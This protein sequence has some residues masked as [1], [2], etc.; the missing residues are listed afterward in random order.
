MILKNSK[1]GIKYETHLKTDQ[2]KTAFIIL[3][4]SLAKLTMAFDVIDDVTV[5]FKGGNVKELSKYFSTTVELSVLN[6]EEMYSANQAELIL[7]DFFLKH[8]PV[9]SKVIHRVVS[10]ANYKFGVV[11]L[12]TTKGSFRISFELKNGSK[13]FNITQIRIEENKD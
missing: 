10:N 11:I 6:K 12:S 2:M 8:P 5:H 9:T 3:F 7:K 1:F 4:L 13:G